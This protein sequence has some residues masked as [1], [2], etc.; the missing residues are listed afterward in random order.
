MRPSLNQPS[1]MSPSF[2]HGAA[3]KLGAIKNFVATRDYKGAVKNVAGRVSDYKK[4]VI[5]GVLNQRV[6]AW[7]S[8]RRRK[9]EELRGTEKLFLF[10]GWATRR[11]V[12]LRRAEAEGPCS[13]VYLSLIN[14]DTLVQ[15]AI[16]PLTS[17]RPASQ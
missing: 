9:K 5:D 6:D 8:D 15:L 1:N 11:V 7:S 2:R 13:S 10:P 16:S 17:S 12:S 3:V 14:P 4:V